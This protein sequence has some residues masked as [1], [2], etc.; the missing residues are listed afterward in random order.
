MGTRIEILSKICLTV[1][2]G[3]LGGIIYQQTGLNL[4][5]SVA[6][7]VKEL[8]R[9]TNANL[10]RNKD[11]SD[12]ATTEQVLDPRTR[13]ILFKMLNKGVFA[14]IHGCVSTGKE[15]RNS[16]CYLRMLYGLS[17]LVSLGKCVPRSD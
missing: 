8:N 5:D 6:S 9:K 7:S 14:E 16:M 10:P 1:G 12:R 15:V 11:K 17:Q 3:S 13:L 4:T 2:V